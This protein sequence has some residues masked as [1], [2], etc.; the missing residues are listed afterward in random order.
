MSLFGW[1]GAARR[2]IDG[3]GRIKYIVSAWAGGNGPVL[4]QIKV[5]DKTARNHRRAVAARA[6]ELSGCIVTLDAGSKCAKESPEIIE[7]DADYV[8]ALK[9]AARKR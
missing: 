9:T 5:A 3:D 8:L 7:S 1:Q 2:A 4:G 6:L